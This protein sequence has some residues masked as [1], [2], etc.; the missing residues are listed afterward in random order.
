MAELYERNKIIL[1]IESAILSKTKLQIYWIIA[2]V[3]M[4]M[5]CPSILW[6]SFILLSF[7]NENS[8]LSFVLLFFFLSFSLSF[9][10]LSLFSSLFLFL[11]LSLYLSFIYLLSVRFSMTRGTIRH[12]IWNQTKL[13]PFY[14]LSFCSQFVCM[15][16]TPKRME[17]FANYIMKEIGHKIP[18]GTTLLDISQYSYRYCMYK[19]GPVL[20]ISVSIYWMFLEW[21]KKRS[22]SNIFIFFFFFSFSSSFSSFFLSTKK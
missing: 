2:N 21:E 10:Y 11:C 8:F 19:V 1:I 12:A 15:G 4:N 9:N 14:S 22:S 3:R 5:K 6:N 20:S 18:A 17:Q 16:G 7:S 13:H